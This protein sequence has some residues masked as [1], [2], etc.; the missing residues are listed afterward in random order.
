MFCLV[1]HNVGSNLIL[2]NQEVSGF[3]YQ[4]ALN[5]VVDYNEIYHKCLSTLLYQISKFTRNLKKSKFENFYIYKKVLLLLHRGALELQWDPDTSNDSIDTAAERELDWTMAHDNPFSEP[6]DASLLISTWDDTAPEL[7]TPT[8]SPPHSPPH[9]PPHPLPPHPL[10]PTTPPTPH[11]PTPHPPPTTNR[12]NRSKESKEVK[13][14]TTPHPP[15]TTNRPNRSKESKEV[16]NQKKTWK[17]S[18]MASIRQQ[19]HKNNKHRFMKAYAKKK[20]KKK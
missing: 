7:I 17:R 13:K 2:K 5:A 9:P 16:I 4:W 20:W 15:P 12:P 14:K 6:S 10:P 3:S 18:G 1:T 8:H 11:H 19:W